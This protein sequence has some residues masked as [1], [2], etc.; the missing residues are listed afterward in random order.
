MEK[1]CVFCGEKPERK[2]NEHVL[3]LWLVEFTGN[4]KRIAQFGYE[5][6]ISPLSGKRTFSFDALKFPSCESCN[7]DFSKLEAA[8]KPI[9]HRILSAD[10]L[11][12]AEFSTLF[13]WFDKIRIG[14][15]LG[16]LYLD[17]NPADVA[18]KFHIIRRIGANDRMLAIFKAD[19]DEE[20]LNF[21]GCDMPS[22]RYTP[23]CFSLRINNY[24]FINISYNDLFSRRIGFPYPTE[25]FM[26][27]DGQIVGRFVGGR[28]RVMVPILKKLFSIRGTELYQPIFLHRVQDPHARRFYDTK[29]VRD[30]SMSWEQGIGKVFIQDN[31]GLQ[32]YPISPSKTWIPTRIHALEALL[33][34]MQILTLE[35]Q[36]YVDSRTLSFEM[37]P[38]EEKQRLRHILGLNKFH[39]KEMIRV[40]REKAQE[41]RMPAPYSIRID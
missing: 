18:P 41:L 6:G 26:R 10:S 3:P 19:G 20:G 38:K 22:F 5:N 17:K 27:E 35:W 11:S 12:A 9:V 7:H 14:L 15:W 30:N 28:N 21:I 39:N 2:T 16:F 32:E 40:L 29:Y 34:E 24:C 23:S 8:A 4:P 31:T 1:F 13:D 25:S 33:F 36:T 37:L